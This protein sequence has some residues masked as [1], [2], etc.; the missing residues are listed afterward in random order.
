MQ[1]VF[2]PHHDLVASSTNWLLR[3]R[4]RR[5]CLPFWYCTLQGVCSL[6]DQGGREAPVPK[7]RLITSITGPLS[8]KVR[9]DMGPFSGRVISAGNNHSFAHN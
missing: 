1:V 9:H 5:C 8:Q 7:Q 2:M 4:A 6:G 3:L